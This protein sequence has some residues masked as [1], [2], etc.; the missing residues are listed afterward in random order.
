MSALDAATS[1][2]K[3][4]ALLDPGGL[5]RLLAKTGRFPPLVLV[6]TP[7][8]G[9][10]AGRPRQISLDKFLSY[11][12]TSSVIIPVD[13]FS[14]TFVAPDDERPPSDLIKGGDIA[15]VEANKETLATGIIDLVGIDQGEDGE[16][17][18]VTGRDLLSQYEDNDSITVDDTPI[19]RNAYTI[20]QVI[21]LLS[22]STRVNK[23]ET[24]DAPSKP[25]LFA[26][27]PGESKLVS[28]QR[29]LEPLNCIAWMNPDG[30]MIVGRPNMSQSPK[31]TLFINKKKR[32]GNVSKIRAVRQ[33]TKVPN[34]I[35]PFWTGQELTQDRTPKQNR[36]L[37]SSEGPKRLRQFGHEVIKTIMVSTPEGDSVQDLA[38]VNRLQAGGQNLMQAYAKREMA[39]AKM[40]ELQVEVSAPGHYN[41]QGEPFR[42]DTV[43]KIESDRAG[44]DENMYLYQVKYFLDEDNGQRSTLSFCPLGAIVSDVRA[45]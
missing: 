27:E 8:E 13:T 44:V 12:F 22:K 36:L 23:F 5:K 2:L 24:Q 6:T 11:E 18:D 16:M 26:T 34:I 39:K 33:L 29:F 25:Y 4:S 40:D 37:N 43:Y 28:L 7:L 45:P 15:R 3:S 17:V 32:E 20:S 9:T 14:F 10:S 31:G 42:T 41:D 35:V 21:N 19:W 30:K 1:L 38:E